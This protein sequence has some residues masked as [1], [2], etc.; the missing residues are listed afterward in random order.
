MPTLR[1]TLH[2]YTVDDLKKRISLI[3][4][5]PKPPRKV[6]LVEAIEQ[7]LT[8]RNLIETWNTLS[9]LEQQ[10]VQ[11]TCYAP[12]LSFN[13]AR[14]AAKYGKCPPLFKADDS[15]YSWSYSNSPTHLSLFIHKHKYHPGYYMP[16][17]LA[18]A[19]RGFVPAPAPLTVATLPSE[20]DEEGILIRLTEH[21]ALRE[22]ST[23]LRLAEQGNFRTTPKTGMPSAAGK[24]TIQA[25]LSGGDFF[26][27]E[28]AHLP[29]KKSWDQEIGDIKPIGWVRHFLAAK[30]VENKGAR[31]RLT[32]AGI[33]A[34]S[35]AP[36]ETI[37]QI[38][39]KWLNNNLF[40]EFNRIDSILGQKAKGH[41]TAKPPRRQAITD[42]LMDCP[43]NEWIDVQKLSS[44]M[45]AEDFAFEVTR[46]PWKLYL[47]D[48]EYGALGYTDF[49]GWNILQFRYMLAFLFEHAAT[50]GL[51]DIAYRHP[52]YALNDY[53]DNWGADEL[54]W[55][56]R[57]DGLRALRITK[58][59]AYCLGLTDTY[60]A[61]QP[62]S[63]LRL[64]V[65]PKLTLQALTDEIPLPERMLIET[66]AEPLDGGLWRLDPTQARDAIE[67][68]NSTTDFQKF[69]EQADDQPIPETV[70]GFLKK[71]QHDAQALK[72]GG[73]AFFYL[74]RDSQTAD[75]LLE[76][77]ELKPI[78]FRCGDTRLAVP[79]KHLAKFQK[80][81]RQL[82]LGFTSNN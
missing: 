31:S 49:G 78:C 82:G 71:A 34:L 35:K 59:G 7:H 23:F 51:I 15:G 40:D 64:N 3:G 56:S 21:D 12:D 81:V 8:G 77:K 38:W 4:S 55:L 10:A 53:R 79:S 9:Q 18:A 6:A 76:Q 54:K 13:E 66:W 61:T 30:L 24:K 75:M 72:S 26:P 27:P 43:V 46:D 5:T 69:L 80:H 48:R 14:I 36:H 29:N 1:E 58:L 19:L 42:A 2:D 37:R 62:A 47:C 73:E 33:K 68:G 67:R 44:Y 50:L 16:E 63:S 28:T 39:Q 20:P 25:S 65:S 22:V 74:C 70:S 60:T 32:P 41:M 17:D 52:E 57:Y 45:Q 11:D